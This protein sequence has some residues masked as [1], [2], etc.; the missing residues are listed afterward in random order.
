[1]TLSGE[2]EYTNNSLLIENKFPKLKKKLF[3]RTEKLVLKPMTRFHR[4][5]LLKMDFHCGSY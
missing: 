1:M 5:K 4:L 3:K 2:K